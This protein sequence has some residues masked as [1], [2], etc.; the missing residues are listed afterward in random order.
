MKKFLK[1]FNNSNYLYIMGLV[2]TILLSFSEVIRGKENNFKIFSQS[3][4][5]FWQGIVPYGENWLNMTTGLDVF[6]YGPVFNIFFTPFA[7]LPKMI[8]PFVWNIFNYTL[9]FYAIQ[10]LPERFTHEIKNRIFLYTFLILACALL[11]FQANVMVASIF[12]FS[13]SLMEKDR[14]FLAILLILFSGFVKVY[15][16]FQ[17]GLLLCYPKFWRNI[18][19][20]LLISIL[21]FFIALINTRIGSIFSYYESWIDMI[22]GHK[23]SRPWQTFFYM[24]PWRNIS[25]FSIYIQLGTLLLLA[26]LFLLNYR[27]FGSVNFR[28]QVLGILMTWMVLFSNAAD[29]HTHLLSMLGF[30]LWYWSQD[31]RQKFDLV[32]FYA[33]LVVVI[34]VPV[35]IICP[36]V[37]MRFLFESLSLHLWLITIAFAR[38]CF[39]TFNTRP[40]ILLSK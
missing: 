5:L 25:A 34:I 27:K 7:Y 24:I 9:L 38:M 4:K 22:M 12:L 10:S 18:F 14:P 2:I 35:D 16:V 33:L 37:I 29:T 8:G 15:G 28:L 36:P 26:G 21:F 17:L 40:S 6:L 11:S 23:D 32:L 19:Y 31:H 39:F 30:M 3:T 1:V 13:F 20:V